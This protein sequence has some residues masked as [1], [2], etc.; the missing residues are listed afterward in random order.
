MSD[1]KFETFVAK[2]DDKDVTFKVYEP[3]PESYKKAVKIRNEV[4]VE[5]LHAKAP[6]RGQLNTLLRARGEWDDERENE[7]NNLTKKILERERQLTIGGIKLSEARKIALEMKNYRNKMRDMLVDRSILDNMTAEGQADNAHFN[8]LVSLC[9]VYNNEKG[10]EVLYFSSMEDYLLK[11]TT[12]IGA[13]AAEKLAN[14]M[15][16]IGENAEKSL[17]ENQ[18]LI[19]WKFVDDKLRLINKDGR[20]VDNEGRFVDE[21]GRYINTDGKFVDKYGNL[22]S[23]LGNYV[24]DTKPFLDENGNEILSESVTV[25]EVKIS[26]EVEVSADVESSLRSENVENSEPEDLLTEKSV[27]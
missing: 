14:L 15:Y 11:S 3:T 26:P 21:N 23:D 16:S 19:K 8:A 20:L 7:Y 6:L 27:E 9:L 25:P 13:T 17:P 5:A 1:R 10:E 12:I 22:I 4:F 2:I 24:V 18:F